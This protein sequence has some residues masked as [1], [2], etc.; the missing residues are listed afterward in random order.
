METLDE[1]Q[2]TLIRNTALAVLKNGTAFYEWLR[3][4]RKSDKDYAFLVGGLGSDYYKSCLTGD[5]VKVSE[6]NSLNIQLPSRSGTDRLRSRSRSPFSR[7]RQLSPRSGSVGSLTPRDRS[8]SRKREE[9][10]R[11]RRK[12]REGRSMRRSPRR[13]SPDRTERLWFEK[14]RSRRDRSPWKVDKKPIDD[15]G[16]MGKMYA[17]SDGEESFRKSQQLTQ[18]LKDKVASIKEKISKD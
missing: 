4:K 15:H 12:Q 7:S 11:N 8:E 14:P 10:A 1:G 3:E 5:A 13:R 6:G 16:R 2:K 17:W 18:A 9:W